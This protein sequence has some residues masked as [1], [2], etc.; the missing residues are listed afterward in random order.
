MRAPEDGLRQATFKL[1]EDFLYSL[2]AGKNL[3]LNNTLGLD[4]SPT[5][6]SYANCANKN[7]VAAA[8]CLIFSFVCGVNA[9]SINS[10]SR[11]RPIQQD[12][13]WGYID[14]TGKI[15]IK[16][17]FVWAEEFSEG[18]AAIENEDG[19]HEQYFAG[20]A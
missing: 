7:F 19:K 10:T 12:G 11:L 1:F 15:V 16:P 13:K 8:Y 17:Q 2:F 14:S 5:V 18:L 9:Q 20:R 3:T 6:L 4:C